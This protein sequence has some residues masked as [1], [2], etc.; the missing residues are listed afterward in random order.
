VQYLRSLGADV[1]VCATHAILSMKDG[2]TAEDRF[3]KTDVS[4]LFTDSVPEKAAGYYES[5]NDW[6]KVISLDYAIAKAF[7]CN[8]VGESI[9]EFL[10]KREIRLQSE[11]LDFVVTEAYNGTFDVE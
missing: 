4:V 6:M 10:S 1:Y 9:S 8:Q 11:K 2:I 5:N 7:Y 3:R